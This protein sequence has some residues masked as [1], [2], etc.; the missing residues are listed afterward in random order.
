MLKILSN[1]VYK[2]V[3]RKKLY[4]FIGLLFVLAVFYVINVPRTNELLSAANIAEINAQTFPIELLDEL[5]GFILPIFMIIFTAEIISGEYKDGT[6]KLPLLRQVSRIRLF[7]AKIGSLAVVLSIILISIMLF[8][9][10]LGAFNLVWGDKFIFKGIV[11]STGK[12]ILFT[13]LIY[14]L[15]MLPLL[16]FSAII[17]FFAVIINNEGTVVGLGI[18]LLI[19]SMIAGSIFDKISLLLPKNYFSLYDV[20]ASGANLREATV[21]YTFNL[22]YGIVFFALSLY[23]FKCKD[24]LS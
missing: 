17:S 5:A 11:L 20:L 8:G 22:I 12:G 6:L 23:I 2:L 15:T 3:I 4:I 10:M 24:I 19:I 21:S 14:F 9:Y 18:G 1:E 16:A 13:I 7:L